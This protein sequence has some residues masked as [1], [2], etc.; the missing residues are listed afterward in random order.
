MHGNARGLD[1]KGYCSAEII[2]PSSSNIHKRVDKE[3]KVGEIETK[4]M[5]IV[6]CTN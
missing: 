2:S 1:A 6:G 5:D 3:I 4:D